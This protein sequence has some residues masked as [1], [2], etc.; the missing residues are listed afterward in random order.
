MSNRKQVIFSPFPALNGESIQPNTQHE[1]D[2]IIGKLQDILRQL[3]ITPSLRSISDVQR[4]D[5]LI[6][7]F[8]NCLPGPITP[9][10]LIRIDESIYVNW[11]SIAINEYSQCLEAV[12]ERTDRNWPNMKSA[13]N[14][15][16]KL[17]AIDC[18][19]EFVIESVSIAATNLPK[20][21]TVLLRILSNIV[22]SATTL[23]TTFVDLSYNDVKLSR[24]QKNVWEKRADEFI[25]ILI[26]LP[27]R[28]ANEMKHS[29]PDTFLIDGFSKILLSHM[30]KMISFVCNVNAMEM[31][32]VFHTGFATKLLNKI[33]TNFH[34]E[35]TSKPIVHTIKALASMS[36]KSPVMRQFVNDT[37]VGLNRQATDIMAVFVLKHIPNVS[38]ILGDNAISRSDNWRQCLLL[39]IPF[40]HFFRE[41]TV[42]VNLVRYL[43][44]NDVNVTDELLLELLTTWSSKVSISR[45]SIDQHIYLSSLILLIVHSKRCS[46]ATKLKEIMFRGVQHHIDSQNSSIR[47]IGMILAELVLNKVNAFA[48]EETLAF[49]Y[50]LF[51][52]T[53]K[54][55]IESLKMLCDLYDKAPSVVTDDTESNELL[56]LVPKK[57]EPPIPSKELPKSN[58][59]AA[60]ANDDLDSDDDLECY[61]MSNDVPAV[62][63]KTPKYLQDLK[64]VIC[65]TDDPDIFASCLENCRRLIV[66]QL[67]NDDALLGIDLLRILMGL[68]EKF[69]TTNFE[70]YRLSGCIAICTIYPKESVEYICVEFNAEAGRYSIANKILM[71]QIIAESAKELSSIEATNETA[72]NKPQTDGHVKKLSNPLDDVRVKE[73][74]KII[75]DRI[76]KKT[77]R[78]ATKTAHPLK[79][80]KRNR[81]ASVAGHFFYSLLH[82]FGRNQL[83]LNATK[84]MKHDTDN[85]LLVNF[86]Q[87]ITTI[88]LA[89]RNCSIVTRFAKDIWLICSL[90][91]F[92]DEAKIRLVVLQM[93][94]SILITVP[95][96]SLQSEFFDDLCELKLWLESC[97]QFNVLKREKNDECR[98]IA[99]H[100]LVLC[101]NALSAA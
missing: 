14:V 61:D 100:V 57:P 38:I 72:I 71:L 86:L 91:R 9:E 44:E 51:N 35:R 33:A 69:C 45:T 64:E 95:K 27:H 39:T 85:I 28:V 94:A 74:E 12:L 65:E 32:Q 90:L 83:T 19:A 54:H 58:S 5:R 88:V 36:N 2:T 21:P 16:E 22:E 43:S 70:E 23:F 87:T 92:N 59:I 49:D 63:D 81:F 55:I 78:F 30:L 68:N 10:K 101:L 66:D 17:F 48:A 47:C 42:C 25:Q 76:E 4:I 7:D 79:H 13:S 3:Q 99:E 75:R 29:T 52:S 11:K 15:F 53:D 80:A 82:G 46:D 41:P 6:Q 20:H 56:L 89:A 31:R 26:S 60:Q 77:R 40:M 24:T 73:A 67:P 97:C 50:S 93:Y 1:T 84:S 8:I 34:V 96:W 37:F 18:N 98:E 62:L